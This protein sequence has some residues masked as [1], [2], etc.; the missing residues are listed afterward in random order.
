MYRV[1]HL[2]DAHEKTAVAADLALLEKEAFGEPVLARLAE[3][4]SMLANQEWDKVNRL[5]VLLRHGLR[6]LDRKLAERLTRILIAHVLARPRKWVSRTPNDC[7]M[8]FT[9]LAEPLAI[10]PNWNRFWAI[11]SD[12]GEA[13][14]R[15]VA[16]LLD[17]IHSRSRDDSRVQ[18]RRAAAGSSDGLESRGHACIAT[19]R[20]SS[21]SPTVDDGHD[22]APLHRSRP[23]RPSSSS[24][25]TDTRMPRP[26]PRAGTAHIETTA[27]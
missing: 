3:L 6:R 16:R 8:R 24:S 21:R 13:R 1:R 7:S 4:Q 9:R 14:Q 18:L 10:D 17:P 5:L 27:C 12:L 19:K 22:G 23:T 2:A 11:A 26:K 20:K 15:N 25:R